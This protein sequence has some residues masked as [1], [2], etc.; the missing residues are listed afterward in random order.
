MKLVVIR[1][2]EVVICVVYVGEEL[3]GV[4]TDDGIAVA[5]VLITR[6]CVVDRDPKSYFS[7]DHTAIDGGG[8][9]PKAG[10]TLIASIT[11]IRATTL[12]NI[13]MRFFIPAPSFCSRATEGCLD[14]R[15]G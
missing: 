12:N 6:V 11:T 5:V 10:A 15:P 13:T 7:P 1:G 9:A 4:A 14:P 8:L 2:L 3:V